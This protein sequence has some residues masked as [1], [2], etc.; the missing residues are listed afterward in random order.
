MKER[1][2][3]YMKLSSKRKITFFDTFP[4]IMSERVK[5]MLNDEEV[6][7]LLVKKIRTNRN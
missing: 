2:I 4:G 3:K 7:K 5:R 6:S 1:I